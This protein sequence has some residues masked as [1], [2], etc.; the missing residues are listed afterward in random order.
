M[1]RSAAVSGFASFFVA[2]IS[3]EIKQIN[4]IIFL[5]N[6]HKYEYVKY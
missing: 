4:L 6:L 5:S 2:I 1:S 3:W